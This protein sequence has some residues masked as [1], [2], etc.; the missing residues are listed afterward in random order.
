[1]DFVQIQV[2][3]RRDAAYLAKEAAQNGAKWAKTR[4]SR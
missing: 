2:L 4:R 3:L 1:M